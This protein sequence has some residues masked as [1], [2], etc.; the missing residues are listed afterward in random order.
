M[1]QVLFD[2]SKQMMLRLFGQLF[3]MSKAQ[4][5]CLKAQWARRSS[6]S[7]SSFEYG[8]HRLF[9]DFYKDST[10]Y[11]ES[12]QILLGLTFVFLS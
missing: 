8:F 12:I 11:I 6:F 5:I 4:I 10:K 2:Q 3:L 1:Q 7:H 9:K